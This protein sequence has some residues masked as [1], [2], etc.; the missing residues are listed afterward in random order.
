MHEF[1]LKFLQSSLGLLALRKIAN[2]SGK[3]ALVARFHLPDS[4][5][6]RKGRSI[7]ALANDDAADADD[8][9]LSCAQIPGEIA[10]VILAIG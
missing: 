1:G 4:E 9:P 6:H 8:A 3:I 7:F 5:L 2:K 10:I